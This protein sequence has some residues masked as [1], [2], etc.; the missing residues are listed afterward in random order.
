MVVESH[1]ITLAVA[2]QA[3]ISSSVEI[4]LTRLADAGA[5][6]RN[7][8]CSPWDFAVEM[9]SL[10]AAGLSTSDLRWLVM[11]GYVEHAQ[12]VTRAQDASRRYRPS[13]N[14]SFGEK[15]CFVLTDLGAGLVGASGNGS[16]QLLRDRPESSR[17]PANPE[18]SPVGLPTWDPDRRVLRL[19]DQVV[20]HFKVPSPSQEAILQAFEEEGWPA[21]IH[22]PLPPQPGQ[23]SKRRLRATLQ[24]LNGNQKNGLVWFRGDGTGERVL[25]ELREESDKPPTVVVLK[26]NRAA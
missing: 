12:E 24:S 17:R 6:A 11:R 2:Q 7:V 13:H 19:G 8:E 14:L 26:R 5:Y 22:D 21:A 10:I 20:K 4:A 25:W 16:P 15:T 9:R 1:A 3:E 18:P 23:D